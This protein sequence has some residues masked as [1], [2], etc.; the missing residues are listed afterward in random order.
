MTCLFSKK[1]HSEK[2]LLTVI[3]IF[4][5]FFKCGYKDFPPSFLCSEIA[6][7]VIPI[8]H[9]DGELNDRNI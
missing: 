6:S 1:S 3:Q 7:F 8:L 9:N 5:N 4:Y 2:L